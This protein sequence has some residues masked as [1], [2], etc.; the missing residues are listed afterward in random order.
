MEGA[1]TWGLNAINRDSASADGFGVHAYVYDTGVRTTHTQ[2]EGR[3]IP[4]LDAVTGQLIQCNCQNTSCAAD[5]HGHGTHCAG[6]VAGK[7]YGVAPNSRIHAVKVLSDSGSGYTSWQIMS[8]NW[9]VSNAM[10]PA[11]VSM[12]L[13]GSGNSQ[14]SKNAIDSVIAAGISVV[15][16]AGNSNADA[17]GYSP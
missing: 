8:H 14:T 11:V 5:R 2:F 10:Q 6:T 16:A 1:A 9:M 13:G 17:C 4:S 15:V 3:A 7:D 12:S